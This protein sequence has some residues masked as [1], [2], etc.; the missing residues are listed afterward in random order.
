MLHFQWD[1]PGIIQYLHKC[2][3]LELCWAI[4][5]KKYTVTE[6]TEQA[7]SLLNR[8]TQAGDFQLKCIVWSFEHKLS[9]ASKTAVFWR[10]KCSLKCCFHLCEKM[11]NFKCLFFCLSLYPL[12][13]SSQ[14]CSSHWYFTLLWRSEKNIF[15]ADLLAKAWWKQRYFYYLLLQTKEKNFEKIVALPF[16]VSFFILALLSFRPPADSVW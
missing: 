7:W 12:H 9:C 6:V 4:W 13:F 15:L 16:I 14:P 10:L 1:L 3:H 5:G 2:K 8:A 11:G